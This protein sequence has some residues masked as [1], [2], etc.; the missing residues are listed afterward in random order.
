MVDRLITIVYYEPVKVIINI[1]SPADVI[2]NMVV[3]HHRVRKSIVTDWVVLFISKFWF[4]LCYFLEI[5]KKLFK[6]FHTQIDSQTKR[7]NS[8]VEAYL[9]AFINWDQNNWANLLLIAEFAYNNAKNVST[10]YTS[11]E[12]NCG[13]YPKIFFKEDFNPCSRFY[14][15]NELAEELRELIEVYFQNLL[16]AQEL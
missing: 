14:S 4:L 5:N 11:F 6:A 13:Y 16:H 7:Q 1:P 15:A 10:D 2:I 8:T 9:R 3:R 12:F